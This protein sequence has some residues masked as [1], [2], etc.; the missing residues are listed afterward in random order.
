MKVRKREDM[1][2]EIMSNI[3]G[4]SAKDYRNLKSHADQILGSKPH[5]CGDTDHSSSKVKLV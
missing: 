2:T 5:K 1:V 4:M 3:S